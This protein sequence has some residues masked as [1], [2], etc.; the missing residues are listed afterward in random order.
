MSMM[1]QTHLHTAMD[2]GTKPAPIWLMRQAGRY[3]PEYRATRGEA[4]GFIDLCMNAELA[5]EVTLQPIRR[6]DFDA[7][8]IFSDILMI[9][10][11]LGQRLWFETGEGPR[12]DPIADTE[13]LAALKTRQPDMPTRLAPVYRAIEKVRAN[14]PAEKSLIGF[15]GAPWTVATYMIAGRGKDEQKAALDLLRSNPT[16]FESMIDLLVECSIAHLKRQIEAGCDTIKVFDSWAGALAV[17]PNLFRAWSM[18]PMQRI[19]DAIK[20]AAPH[21]K[22]IVF[23][24][25]AGELYTAFTEVPSIDCLAI[26]NS[27]PD[28]WFASTI[29][30]HKAVQGNLPPDFMEGDIDP[31]LKRVDAVLKAFGDG[32][33]VFN[34]SHGITPQGRIE[35]VEAL[36]RHVRGAA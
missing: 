5:A 30:P 8:I 9:P 31:M 17:D 20:A 1:T 21:V 33:F 11:G 3:L 35:A 28:D 18:D 36:I 7:A 14:L 13:G 27:M 4:G 22:T 15:V 29:Q 24:R 23:P 10:Y 12:L 6:F 2:R 32:R 25:G 34:L 16:V 26:D 19:T